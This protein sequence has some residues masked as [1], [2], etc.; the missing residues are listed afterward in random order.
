MYFPTK[1]NLKLVGIMIF[2]D[3]LVKIKENVG[4]DTQVAK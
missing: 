3:G 2:G 1:N 4:I